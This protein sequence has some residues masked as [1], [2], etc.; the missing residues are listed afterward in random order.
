MSLRHRQ[1]KELSVH[2]V[3]SG[4][5]TQTVRQNLN[6]LYTH[7]YRLLQSNTYLVR[8]H[9]WSVCMCICVSCEGPVPE[10]ARR[11]D[12]PG[13]GVTEAVRRHVSTGNQTWGLGKSS[14][15]P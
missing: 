13:T 6:N 2:H 11:L 5:Q 12:S 9:A 4:Y 10:E 3:G 14:E 15:A 7:H 1:F 8:A